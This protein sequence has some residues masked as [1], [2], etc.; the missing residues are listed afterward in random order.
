MEKVQ[1]DKRWDLDWVRSRAGGVMEFKALV[2][3]M[4]KFIKLLLSYEGK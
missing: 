3:G 1:C 4:C 2:I